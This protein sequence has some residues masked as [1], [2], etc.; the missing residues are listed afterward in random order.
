M[1]PVVATE[2]LSHAVAR[3]E[4]DL[5][6]EAVTERLLNTVEVLL[7]RESDRQRRADSVDA[8]SH[9]PVRRKGLGA[10]NIP[11]RRRPRAEACIKGVVHPLARDARVTE[12]ELSFDGH[13]VSLAILGDR[14]TLA[15]AQPSSAGE[16]CADAEA[17]EGRDAG[18]H[19]HIR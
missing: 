12:C 16:R 4:R 10:L 18:A 7:E 3:T 6:R 15:R 5:W 9:E 17:D 14:R 2:R 8:S 19:D 1:V 13:E 11:A